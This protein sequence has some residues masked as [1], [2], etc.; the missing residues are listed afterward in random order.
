MTSEPRVLSAFVKTH[1]REIDSILGDDAARVRAQMGPEAIAEIEKSLRVSWVP[2]ETHVRLNAAC[3]D[4][5]GRDRA[6]EAC[7]LTVLES[8]EQPFLKPILSGAFAI[9]GS[10]FERFVTWTPKAWPALF[11]D[12]G[13]LRWQPDGDAVGRLILERADVM[14]LESPDYIEG[15]AGA[16]SALFDVTQRHG[17]VRALGGT[18]DLEIQLSW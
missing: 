15:L 18:R 12:V 2:L 8:F 14:I 10:S 6:R 1:L 4:V 9:L 3:F 5:A 7:R 11:R 17:E 16:F 13:T